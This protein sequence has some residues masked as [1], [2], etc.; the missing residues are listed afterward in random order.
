MSDLLGK[1][2]HKSCSWL[3]VPGLLSSLLCSLQLDIQ[4]GFGAN[5][6]I[7]LE[8]LCPKDEL[9]NAGALVPVVSVACGA[10][11]SD[12]GKP[13]ELLSVRSKGLLVAV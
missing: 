4:E 12:L 1:L 13:Q 3:V 5:R 2:G 7:S 9:R 10:A 8:H 11:L 6:E